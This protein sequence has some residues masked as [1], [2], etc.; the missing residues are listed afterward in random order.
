MRSP[1]TRRGWRTSRGSNGTCGMMKRGILLCGLLTAGLAADA[2]G[3]PQYPYYAPPSYAPQQA[4]PQQPYYPRNDSQQPAYAPQPSYPQQTH[5]TAQSSP[6]QLSN[7]VAPV[8]LYP[9]MLLSEVLA[10]STYPLELVQAEQWVRSNPGLQGRALVEA[11][12]QQNWD[13]S[14]QAL[15]AFP[16]VL[17]LLTRDIQWTT[18]LGNAFLAQQAGVM[19]AI[20][21]LRAEARANGRLRDTAQQRVILDQG[22]AEQGAIEIQPTDPQVV[23]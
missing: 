6:Q 12:K 10:A 3:P 20:Q 5:A 4:Y 11:A 22:G 2:Q 16:D 14:V 23:Y 17:Q 15:V 21:Q 8:A 13:P 19:D 18:D 7:L 1:V 9:D